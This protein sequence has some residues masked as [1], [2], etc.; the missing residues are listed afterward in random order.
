MHIKSSLRFV[1]FQVE[2][3]ANMW[4]KVLRIDEI[5]TKTLVSIQNNV[6]GRKLILHV[7]NVKTGGG[8]IVLSSSAVRRP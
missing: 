5:E 3:R 2:D 4:K 6:F 7:P 8:S 1:I